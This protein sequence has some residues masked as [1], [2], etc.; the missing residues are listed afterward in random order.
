MVLVWRKGRGKAADAQEMR[1]DEEISVYLL[2]PGSSCRPMGSRT[3]REYRGVRTVTAS[4]ICFLVA[5]FVGRLRA[6]TF[7]YISNCFLTLLHANVRTYR[8]C[9]LACYIHL[10]PRCLKSRGK[11]V[12]S[13]VSDHT[14][15]GRKGSE[16]YHED[17]QCPTK[18][19]PVCLP[20]T[21]SCFEWSMV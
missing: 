3:E 18:R 5:G 13:S 2:R 12:A 21:E 19:T 6:A 7:M 15:R 10:V 14:R 17:R 4:S 8:P 20:S 9:S 1:A 11:R 16:R